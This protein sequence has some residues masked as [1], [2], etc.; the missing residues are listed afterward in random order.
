MTYAE[1][2]Q[3]RP[4]VEHLLELRGCTL[5]ALIAVLAVFLACLPF[6]R[7]IYEGLSAPLQSQLPGGMIATEVAT[8]LL[9]PLKLCFFV[10]FCIAIPYVL[11]QLWRFIAPGLYRREARMMLPLVGSG[12]ALFFS[13]IAFAYFVVFPLIFGFFVSVAPDGV[14]VMTDINAYL[15]FVI[16]LFFAFG[17]AFETPV[18]I[19]VLV[20]SGAVERRSLIEKRPYLVVLFFVV[21]MLMTPPDIF[22]QVLLAV[23]MW[24]LFELGLFLTRGEGGE[25]A[26]SPPGWGLRHPFLAACL[27]GLLLGGILGA[28]GMLAAFEHLFGAL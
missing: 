19:L 2:D 12:V 8:P 23:P 15:N 10:A 11:L 6:S 1:E 4:I 7:Q 27:C 18:L 5:R 13:G 28:L 21:G 17:L 9:V 14:Q 24:L 16:K 20:R 3:P 26:E 22:S 25:T